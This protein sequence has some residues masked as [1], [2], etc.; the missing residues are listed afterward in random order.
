MVD[1]IKIISKV[2]VKKQAWIKFIYLK[3]L[4]LTESFASTSLDEKA[5]KRRLKSQKKEEKFT[6]HRIKARILNNLFGIL[7]SFQKK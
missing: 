1:K 3:D 7:S 4:K 2:S 6:S 5:R